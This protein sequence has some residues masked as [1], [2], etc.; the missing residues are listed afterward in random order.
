M[1]FINDRANLDQ[2][3]L[4][5]QKI[6]QE[7]IT[8]ANI[9]KHETIL[10]IGP[11]NGVLTKII[12]DQCHKLIVIEKDVRLKDSLEKIPGIEI[13]FGNVLET[14]IPKVDKIITSLPYSIIEPF[15]KKLITC[16]FQEMYMLMGENYIDNCLNKVITK[17]SI[18]TNAY[19][20]VEK[21]L[22]VEPKSF[23]YPPRT[24]SCIA[25]FTKVPILELP[26]SYQIYRL[27]Y[28]YQDMKIKNALRETL[29]TL[30][31]LTKKEA[32]GKIA[33]LN[34][35]E[36]ILEN[37]FATISNQDLQT[38]NSFIEAI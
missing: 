28:F 37:K 12:K 3:F 2:H 22:R 18:I 5:D 9:K 27:L 17:L 33:S 19:F 6:I 35:P 1:E 15:I 26:K 32:K 36:C 24:M 31:N 30:D 10:E 11:G 8:L 16:D 29:I 23:D 20:K 21:L 7:Y 38:L 34:I 25:R 13:I 4:I 14:D